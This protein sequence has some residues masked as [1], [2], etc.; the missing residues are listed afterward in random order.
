M[1]FANAR[2]NVK[3]IVCVNVKRILQRRGIVVTATPPS[4]SSAVL[5]NSVKL[6]ATAAVM[7]THLER[8][9]LK[10]F[11]RVAYIVKTM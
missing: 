4:P 8:F 11:A 9:S 10:L 3:I 1:R 7:P 6:V 5:N 2:T